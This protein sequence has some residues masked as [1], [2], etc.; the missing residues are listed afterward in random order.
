MFPSVHCLEAKD[1]RLTLEALMPM[2][3][4]GAVKQ[5][6][7]CIVH[8]REC[9]VRATSLHV[10][11]PPCVDWSPIGKQQQVAGPTIVYF[12]AWVGLRRLL[13][14]P[15]VIHENVT[16]FDAE[17]LEQTLGDKYTVATA[18]LDSPNFG[19]PVR[20]DRRYTVLLHKQ[21]MSVIRR[22]DPD[23]C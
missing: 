23:V 18:E 19:M 20:R 15:Q 6:A 5:S 1:K 11:G 7:F 8:Q 14:E 17:I 4:K 16:R 21:K 9:S 10:A 2:L 22:S 13:E 3:K 12:A